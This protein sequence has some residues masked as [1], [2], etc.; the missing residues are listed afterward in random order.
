MYRD[1]YKCNDTVQTTRKR[2]HLHAL[3]GSWPG[4][5]KVFTSEANRPNVPPSNRGGVRVQELNLESK[6]SASY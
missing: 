5:A 1:E 2:P 6:R 4:W 3:G